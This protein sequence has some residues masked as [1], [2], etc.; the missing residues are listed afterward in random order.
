MGCKVFCFVGLQATFLCVFREGR[1]GRKWCCVRLCG[2]SAQAVAKEPQ[3]DASR[4]NSFKTFHLFLFRNRQWAAKSGQ[5]RAESAIGDTKIIRF[6]CL[7]LYCRLNGC[8]LSGRGLSTPRLPSIPGLFLCGRQHPASDCLKLWT[9]LQRGGGWVGVGT[10]RLEKFSDSQQHSREEKKTTNY[11]TL[12]EPR[13]FWITIKVRLHNYHV[14][15]A[16][17]GEGTA[18]HVTQ[19]YFFFL[20]CHGNSASDADVSLGLARRV[21]THDTP[22]LSR[23]AASDG[24][25]W[26][27]FS[28]R[29]GWLMV[30]RKTLKTSERSSVYI[31]A[32]IYTQS[33][34]FGPGME[35]FEKEEEGDDDSEDEDEGQQPPG[36][37]HQSNRR[38]LLF[39]PDGL[40]MLVYKL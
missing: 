21:T 31:L 15:A 40:L 34:K 14:A 39:L 22:Q 6:C 25:F 20:R 33:Q 1:R 2:K 13:R 32:W 16:I 30:K 17:I 7:I 24:T 18:S 23:M 26:W 36:L 37:W 35:D 29:P 38:P 5:F 11:K 10:Q 9:S 28:L 3:C 12:L 19:R 8:P 4:A 27:D